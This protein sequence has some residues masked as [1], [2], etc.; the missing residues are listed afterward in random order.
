[1]RSRDLRSER[2]ASLGA[3][4]VVGDVFDYDVLLAAMQGVTRAFYLPPMDPFVIH[5]ATAFALAVSDAKVR[6]IVELSQWLAN[7]ASPSLLTREHW[8]IDQMFARIPGITLTI[9]N[10]GFLRTTS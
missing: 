7:P 1:V 5:S 10:P 2:L 9:V 6:S 3:E 4:V 8:Q